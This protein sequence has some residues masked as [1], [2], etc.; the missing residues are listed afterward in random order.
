MLLGGRLGRAR[1]WAQDAATLPSAWVWCQ[2]SFRT[3]FFPVIFPFLLKWP[4]TFLVLVVELQ[5]PGT[6]HAVFNRHFT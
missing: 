4:N 1:G 2:V 5:C 6:K 3:I